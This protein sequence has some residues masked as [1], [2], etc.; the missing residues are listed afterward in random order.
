MKYIKYVRYVVYMLIMRLKGIKRD[1]IE[2]FKG[3]E[4]A[5]KYAQEVFRKWTYFTINIIGMEIEVEGFEN[6]PDKTC[7]FMGNHQSILDIPVMRYSTQ[8]TLDFVAKKELAKAP[9]IGYWITHVK[10][11]TIDRDNIRE[12]MKAINQ[13]VNNIKDGY[14]F[15][16]FP[17]GTRSKDG[18]IHEF[19]RGSIKIASKS[20]APIIPVAIKG[21]S[22]CFEDS[23]EFVPGKVKVIFGEAIETEN[24]SKE[25]ERELMLRVEESVRSLYEKI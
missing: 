19:K 24:I 1:Y 23:K 12:G 25:V 2:K 16:I 15:T 8:R 9:L 5:W 18:K 21:T 20:K 11:V 4:E 10:S 14:N 13:A 6:I 7:V 3:E 17:E 22:A